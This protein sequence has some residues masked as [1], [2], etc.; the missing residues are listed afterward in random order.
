MNFIV[1]ILMFLVLTLA[2]VLYTYPVLLS[3]KSAVAQESDRQD[4]S[5][6]DQ[7]Y[8][9]NDEYQDDYQDQDTFNPYGNED[10]QDQMDQDTMPDNNDQSTTDDSQDEES[11]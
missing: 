2:P 10:E 8:D 6:Q 11:F 1:R 7:S 9:N 5:N 3:T 4:Q